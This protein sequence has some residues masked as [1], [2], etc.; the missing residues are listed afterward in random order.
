MNFKEFSRSGSLDTIDYNS[1][2]AKELKKCLYVFLQIFEF[3]LVDYVL[4]K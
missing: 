3:T 2:A 1:S 4:H